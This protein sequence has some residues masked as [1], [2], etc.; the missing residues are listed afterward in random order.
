MLSQPK[1]TVQQQ[2]AKLFQQRWQHLKEHITSI[3]PLRKA[4]RLQEQKTYLQSV[5][6]YCANNIISQLIFAFTGRD[7]FISNGKPGL[8]L[9]AFLTPGSGMGESQH[10]DPGSGM[11]NPDHIF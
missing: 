9:G 5:S 6:R 2:A 1:S 7:R 10:P 4:D 3:L 8:G 11:N